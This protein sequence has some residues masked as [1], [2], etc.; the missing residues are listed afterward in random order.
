MGVFWE[1][2]KDNIPAW[3]LITLAMLVILSGIVLSLAKTYEILYKKNNKKKPK[4]TRNSLKN[5]HFFTEI[6][7]CRNYSLKIVQLVDVERTSVMKLLLNHKLEVFEKRFY[8]FVNSVDIEDFSSQELG[9]L[10][11]TLIFSSINEYEEKFKAEAKDK[12]ERAIV[13]LVL[14][15]FNDVHL[16]RGHEAIDS[17]KSIFTVDT[18][19]NYT[20]VHIA[21]YALLYP[22]TSL[23]GDSLKI[24]HNLNGELTGKEFSG[25]IFKHIEQ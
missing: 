21:L 12:S 17:I 14:N 15:K 24:L 11:V 1:I 23:F 6:S 20:K 2:V 25:M 5:H 7:G 16:K 4:I 3:V 13:E 18:Q 19:D 10:F 22:F 9:G 8:D